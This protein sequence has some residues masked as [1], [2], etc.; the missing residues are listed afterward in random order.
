MNDK[1]AYNLIDEPWIPVLMKDGTN[2]SVSLGEIFADSDGAIADLALNPYERVAVFRL[3]L[4]IA[5]AALGAEIEVPTVDGPE[6]LRIPAGTQPGKIITMKGKGVPAL[7]GGTRG[8]QKVI[9]DVVTPTNLTGEQRELLEKL[10]V[11]LGT[12]TTVASKTSF[13][14]R[15]KEVINGD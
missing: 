4:C 8:D 1:N 3:L 5:Q 10:A 12:E 6:K 7:R 9:V 14:D 2:R 13:W 15:L 11:S